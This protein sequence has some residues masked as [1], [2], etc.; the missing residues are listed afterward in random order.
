MR[1]RY[2]L[3]IAFILLF[4]FN[5]DSF[6]QTY[7]V[8]L[9]AFTEEI[10]QS[11]FSYAGYS[12]VYADKDHNNFIRYT[13]GEYFTKEAATDVKEKAISGGF[14]NTH[15]IELDQPLFAYA[16]DSPNLPLMMV[17]NKEQLYIR[18]VTFTKE[19]LGL[20]K[21]LLA[22]LEN[23]LVVMHENPN[24]KLRIVAHTDE[25]G[26]KNKNKAISKSRARIIQNFLL[27]NNIPAYRVK[28]KV[29]DKPSPEV[30]FQEA[31]LP[32]NR[33]FNRRIILTL[34][35]LKEE[36]VVDN[37]TKTQESKQSLSAV[38]DMSR[39]M[40]FIKMV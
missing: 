5:L 4:L 23:A 19:E 3:F 31:G 34:V 1:K 30:Y 38:E 36:I 26:T 27:A 15:I 22:S 2:T 39:L 21:P 32:K 16:G 6:A 11:F 29:S 7:Q 40:K 35:D 17:P 10:D 25:I 18:S 37:F 24:L 14:L 12:N 20:T 9:A 8:H 13:L 28:M 33:D